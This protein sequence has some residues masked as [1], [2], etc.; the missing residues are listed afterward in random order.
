MVHNLRKTPLRPSDSLCYNL[1]AREKY[2]AP[3][4]ERKGNIMSNTEAQILELF[5][6]LT[7]AEKEA[8]AFLAQSLSSAKREEKPADQQSA[9]TQDS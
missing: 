1:P 5:R 4:P 3:E 8:F 7:P 9:P 2:I 6:Q